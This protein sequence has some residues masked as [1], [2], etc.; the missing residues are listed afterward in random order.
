[1]PIQKPFIQLKAE[2][3]WV[4]FI[5]HYRNVNTTC[6]NNIICEPAGYRLPVTWPF[7]GAT[8]GATQLAPAAN[9]AAAAHAHAAAAAAQLTPGTPL[10]YAPRASAAAAAAA[11]RRR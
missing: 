3:L 2:R 4:L 9:P 8:V 7:L 6:Y 10:V 5:A 1:M 11:Q